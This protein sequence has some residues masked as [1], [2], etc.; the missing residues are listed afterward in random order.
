[1]GLEPVALRDG[2]AVIAHGDGQEMEL[3]VRIGDPARERMKPQA[4]NWF[5]APRPGA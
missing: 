4:S 3:D 5:D 2:G 1:M